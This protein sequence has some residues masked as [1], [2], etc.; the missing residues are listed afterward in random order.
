MIEELS[1]L[2]LPGMEEENVD[3][4]SGVSIDSFVSDQPSTSLIASVRSVEFGAESSARVGI[5]VA[6]ATFFNQRIL[7]MPRRMKRC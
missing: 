7:V 4:M 3:T 6:A 5:L 1:A 2:S